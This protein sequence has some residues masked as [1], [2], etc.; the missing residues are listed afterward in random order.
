FRR[1][2]T[3]WT[4]PVYIAFNHSAWRC[5]RSGS[6]RLIL[7]VIPEPTLYD[8]MICIH[9][10][11]EYIE[12]TADLDPC[13]RMPLSH[14]TVNTSNQRPALRPMFAEMSSKKN[15]PEG[16]FR[17]VLLIINGCFDWIERVA[18]WIGANLRDTA[19]P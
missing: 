3:S 17:I 7:A 16:F 11:L 9:P 10:A 19:I 13:P 18:I 4:D 2:K 6:Q 14:S 1:M 8:S 5:I 15:E 12:L